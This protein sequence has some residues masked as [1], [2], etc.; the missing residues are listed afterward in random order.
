MT[1]TYDLTPEEEAAMLAIAAHEQQPVAAICT[2]RFQERI[3]KDVAW[4]EAKVKDDVAAAFANLTKR[5][6]SMTLAQKQRIN[7]IVEE[8]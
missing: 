2:A 6:D 4:H 1:F 5:W 8:R 7:A 3:A